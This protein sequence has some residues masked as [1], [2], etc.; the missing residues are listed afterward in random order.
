MSA[1]AYAVALTGGIATGK[2]SAAR[3]FGDWGIEIIDLDSIAHQVLNR[4]RE[5]IVALFG[6]ACIV[7]GSVDRRVLGKQVFS[8]SKKRKKLL[9]KRK[10]HH[11]FSR[12]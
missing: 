7:G 12:R 8:D 1:F 3:L 2:S 6:A 9:K 5:K 11:K 4:Q 10:R